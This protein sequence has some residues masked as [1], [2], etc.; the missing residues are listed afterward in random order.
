[1]AKPTQSIAVA[2]EDM[3]EH[4]APAVRDLLP[5]RVCCRLGGSAGGVWHTQV[6][7]PV[8]LAF[9]SYI[10]PREN[11]GASSDSSSGI[12]LADYSISSRTNSPMARL[13]PLRAVGET[14]RA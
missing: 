8:T 3:S 6:V 1:M 11:L 7:D 13:F 5:H 10:A 14:V 12:R 9:P 2:F 4:V